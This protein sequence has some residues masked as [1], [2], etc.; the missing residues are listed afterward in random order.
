MNFQEITEVLARQRTL[1][2]RGSIDKEKQQ[3]LCTALSLLD[4]QGHGIIR[5]EIDSGGGDAN[6]AR[7]LGD[8]IQSVRSSVHGVVVGEACSSAFTVLQMC[9]VR[10]AFPNARFL[11]HSIESKIP[12][13]SLDREHRLATGTHLH[14]KNLYELAKRSGQPLRQLRKWSLM[15][16][17]FR[18]DEALELGFIDRIERPKKKG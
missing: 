5:L 2:L 12:A 16:R 14:E 17:A 10:S 4:T 3:V 15:E 7:F 9:D 6:C 8:V 1:L 13:E 11:F 18:A